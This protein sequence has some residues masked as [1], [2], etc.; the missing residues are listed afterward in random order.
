MIITLWGK[1]WA[2]KGTCAKIIS[3]KLW[4]EH[5]SIGGIKRKLAEKM[6]MSIHEFNLLWEQPGK[7]QEFDF[8][9]EEYQ[10]TLPLD[11]KIVLDSRLSYRCQPNAFKVFLNV[12]PKVWAE[13]IFSAERTTDNHGSPEKTLA[14]AIARNEADSARY[15]RLYQTDPLDMNNYDLIIDT[16]N[17]KEH[18]A[19]EQVIAE[20]KARYQHI[21]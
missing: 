12:D 6:W 8:K 20:F 5:I 1:E 4:Y 9:Y 13:R 14:D 17:L 7:E 18:E 16:T 11:S 19:A 15:M 3:E 21:V 2:G 10:K